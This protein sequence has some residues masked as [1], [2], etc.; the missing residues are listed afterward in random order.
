MKQPLMN[1]L[2]KPTGLGSGKERWTMSGCGPA[3]LTRANTHSTLSSATCRLN[4]ALLPEQVLGVS[5]EY[6]YNGEAYKV[7]E[8]VDDYANVRQDQVIF[9]KMLKATNP[10]VGLVSPAQS[11]L[12]ARQI[13]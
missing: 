8:M 3:S 12:R 10:G 5:Y 6:I 9:L 4:T 11:H 7:G 1:I 2:T 13:H